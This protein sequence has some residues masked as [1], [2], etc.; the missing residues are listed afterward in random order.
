MTVIFS[1]KT[2][3][4]PLLVN[5]GKIS[6]DQLDKAMAHL[7]TVA[8]PLAEILISLGFV[9]SQDILAAQAE[10]LGLKLYHPQE[11]DIFLPIELPKIFH[12][13]HPFALIQR[14]EDVILVTH[15]PEDSEIMSGA[16]IGL[17]MLHNQGETEWVTPLADF[18][19]IELL[20]EAE[21]RNLCDD[22]YDLG[23]NKPEAEQFSLDE[24]DVV[25]PD[26]K[27]DPKY[28]DIMSTCSSHAL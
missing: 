15:S 8:Q 25:K 5:R 16:E 23:F 28:W 20:G 2:E 27:Y 24:A 18:F 7:D 13:A 19:N 11:T 6:Q 14:D 22:H 9:S 26:P 10:Q 4:G 17:Q 21:L 12:Q 1:K 3:M